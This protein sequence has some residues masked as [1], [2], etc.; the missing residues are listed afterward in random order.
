MRLPRP[1]L[2]T[3]AYLTDLV[4]ALAVDHERRE[5][6]IIGLRYDGADIHLRFLA[7]TPWVQVHVQSTVGGEGG[8]DYDDTDFTSSEEVDCQESVLQDY[9][10][11]GITPGH[12]YTIYLIPVEKDTT[13]TILFDGEGGRPDNK[14]FV[15]FCGCGHDDIVITEAPYYAVGDGATDNT[16]A[17]QAAIDDAKASGRN[18]YV[19]PGEFWFSGE[20]DLEDA[21]NVTI[22]GVG[23]PAHS[24]NRLV[25]TGD[26]DRAIATA[27]S[28]GVKLKNL[29]LAYNNEDFEGALIDTGHSAAASDVAYLVVEDCRL[30]GLG[31]ARSAAQLIRLDKVIFSRIQGSA[32][33]NA[34]RAI[35][36]NGGYANGIR[37]IDNTFNNMTLAPVLNPGEGWRMDDNG[38]EPLFDGSAG[39]VESEAGEAYAQGLRYAGN[40][41]GDASVG[42]SPW[43]ILKVLGADIDGGNVFG[44]TGGTDVDDC[45]IV[46]LDCEGVHI[47]GNRINTYHGIKLTAAAPGLKVAGNDYGG[48]GTG[49]VDLATHSPRAWVIGNDG[50]D[51]YVAQSAAFTAA[52]GATVDNTY[53]AE[54]AGVIENLRTRVAE[55]EAIL[56]LLGA[57]AA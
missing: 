53:G 21:F 42:G 31:D 47:D 33:W 45:A 32:F 23:G 46:L 18:I 25:Y 43:V 34:N 24:A 49:I 8:S 19:P 55:M 38:F 50:I 54:E 39:A 16:A 48:A 9:V 12:T 20:L 57:A 51:D 15:E 28:Q 29:F 30:A 11:E 10:I 52:D 44:P 1:R 22:R 27:S 37:L 40:W 13:G 6:R 26:G 2:P 3:E 4:T 35:E 7:R 36:R 14:V 41:H 17:L 5:P 56:E